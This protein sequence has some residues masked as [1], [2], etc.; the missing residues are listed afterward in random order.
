MHSEILFSREIMWMIRQ[1]TATW[2]AQELP[3]MHNFEKIGSEFCNKLELKKNL[4]TCLSIN[5]GDSTYVGP[6]RN[7]FYKKPEKAG[8][9]FPIFKKIS[10]FKFTNS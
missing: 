8:I 2:V 7:K 3:D 10:Q 9:K 4:G 5:F 6:N 1:W